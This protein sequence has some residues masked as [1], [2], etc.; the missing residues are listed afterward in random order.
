MTEDEQRALAALRFNWAWTPDDV[1]GRSGFHVDG[2][3]VAMEREVLAGLRQAKGPDLGSP[4]GLVLQGQRGSGKTHLLGWVRRQVQ[5]E[6]GYFFL[7][8][9]DQ[10]RAFWPSMEHAIR[11]D[12]MRT[13]ER[14]QTQLSLM[15]S[16]LAAL[17]GLPARQAARITGVDRPSK[18]DLDDLVLALR[19]VDMQVA[20]ECQETLRAL[21]LFAS[22]DLSLSPLGEDFLTTFEVPNQTDLAEWGIRLRPRDPHRVVR[23]VS[24]LLALIGP[25]VFAVDQ[26]DSID[27]RPEDP[28]YLNLAQVADGL[29]ALRDNTR[30]A[31]TLVSCIPR[32]W[33]RLKEVTIGTAAD[34]FSEVGILA[35]I[36]DAGIARAL[37]TQRLRAAY[38]DV[39]FVPPHPTWP[40]AERAFEG[41][42]NQFTPRALLR[43]VHTHVQY[44]LRT[45]QVSELDRLDS[46]VAS[47]DEVVA[48]PL[49]LD[50]LD[51]RYT[52]LKQ[53]ADVR[54]A[55]DP[56]TESR[57]MPA[58]LTAG[59]TAWMVEHGDS[60]LEWTLDPT[61]GGPQ[62]ALHARLRRNLD[63]ETDDEAH[64]SFRAVAHSNP[65]AAQTRLRNAHTEAGLRPDGTRDLVILRNSLWPHGRVT[66]QQV[67]LLK[68]SGGRDRPITD[69]DLRTFRALEELLRDKPP[70]LE[71][72]L[73]ARKP[74]SRTELLDNIL[75]KEVDASTDDPPTVRTAPAVIP[76]E[77]GRSTAV[78]T[79]PEAAPT[80]SDDPLSIVIG[81]NVAD[82][83]PVR[84]TLESLRKHTAIFAGTG[85]GK[86]VLI[87]RLVE[88]CALRGVSSIV[89]DPNNDLARLGDPWPTPPDNWGPGDPGRATRYISGT[90]LVVW[91]PGRQS[92][93][94]LSFQPLPDFASV[95]DDPD[96]FNG[97][98]DAA[99]ASLVPRANVTGANN[100]AK[101]SR[102]VLR[103]ALTSYARRGERSL[104][105]FISVLA[106]LPDGVSSLDDAPKLAAE[107]AK[108][109]RA[110]KVN[111]ALFGGAGVAVDPGLLLTPSAGKRAR[112]SVI[113]FIGLSSDEQRQSFVNQLQLELFAW[114]KNNPAGDRPLGSLL[115]MDEAQIVAPAG[116]FTPSTQ[117]T[118]MLAAQA[119]KYGLGLMFATQKPK[120]LNNSI[121]GNTSTLVIGQLNAPVQIQAAEDMAQAKGGRIPNIGA[122]K[123]GYFYA[124][125]EG[126]RF[127]R[128]RSPMCLSHHPKSALTPEE[129][130][131]RARSAQW[132][133][134]D[135]DAG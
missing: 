73:V 117:S 118:L 77:P 39:G 126:S 54:S 20:Q 29:M 33:L 128:L 75:G 45:S 87:R 112:I 134:E 25:T 92:G 55:L 14:R 62:P 61:P 22:S 17:V 11:R 114:I 60:G 81:E 7:V 121:P 91:T 21:V 119:R 108:S 12:L 113:S 109:L 66:A 69:D 63:E 80:G 132:P 5:L 110:A 67:A 120:G 70:G 99:V 13:N 44:C 36:P 59:L 116:A 47:L 85:S 2:M 131:R 37:V 57:V 64:W 52:E 32:T 26:I 129:V 28:S 84:V 48:P 16:R 18:K 123:P 68:E 115:V 6:D 135:P 111:D 97:A 82:G 130:A 58:L 127:Q 86:T 51:R 56:A 35:R 8:D 31:M 90:E 41:I 49:D 71:P 98:V 42:G 53:H 10:G 104:E 88:E 15:L 72:W 103:E 105:G 101:W 79:E 106:D 30:R 125:N 76:T 78:W 50:P 133:A 43:R 100:K 83:T 107:L 24:W 93:R 122:L 94:P 89:L 65:R 23:D 9:L 102:A 34:R 124:A 46:E 95:R 38:E 19:E 3:H 4:I 96:E 27:N 74:A 1:W 40:V